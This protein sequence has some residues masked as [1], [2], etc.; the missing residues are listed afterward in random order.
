MTTTPR[1]TPI[2]SRR[3]QAG[4][5]AHGILRLSS[6]PGEG[7]NFSFHTGRYGTRGELVLALARG[8]Y[9]GHL[10]IVYYYVETRS[11]SMFGPW[12][13]TFL[14]FGCHSAEKLP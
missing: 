11:Y 3:G 8:S 4:T 9:Q 1:M 12:A 2:P 7:G 6:G 13:P 14:V 10:G 5:S